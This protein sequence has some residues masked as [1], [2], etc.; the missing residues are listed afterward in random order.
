MFSQNYDDWMQPYIEF[1]NQADLLILPSENM[2]TRLKAEG[3]TVDSIIYQHLWDHPTAYQPEM[4]AFRRELTFLGS[5]SRFPF[6]REWPYET[7]LRLFAAD[8]QVDAEQNIEYATRA[9]TPMKSCYR[10]L[11]GGWLM[12][13]HRHPRSTGAPVLALECFL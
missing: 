12:L 3:L 5:Q 9:F 13:E 4:A 8:A 11:M 10:Y 1:F 7:R 2:A 6:T